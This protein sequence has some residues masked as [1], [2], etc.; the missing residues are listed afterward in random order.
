MNPMRLLA[1]L[2]SLSLLPCTF[3]QRPPGADADPNAVPP[4]KEPGVPVTDRLTVEK[5]SSCHKADDK[6]NLTRIS[7]IGTHGDR[8]CEFDAATMKLQKTF[9]VDADITTQMV[10]VTSNTDSRAAR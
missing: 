10:T 7:I 8:H 3:A 5:C 6:G 2:I 9:N 4:E 1:F